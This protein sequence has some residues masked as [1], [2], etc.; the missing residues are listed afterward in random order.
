M[1]TI[2]DI[3]E[4]ASDELHKRYWTMCDQKQEAVDP[5]TL[6]LP[7]W[8]EEL[9]AEAYELAVWCEEH[10]EGWHEGRARI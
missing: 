7:T 4:A 3:A 6:G 2:T 8:A 1:T 10:P 9:L 5:E